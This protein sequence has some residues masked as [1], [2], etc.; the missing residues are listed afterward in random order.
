VAV[1]VFRIPFYGDINVPA[2]DAGAVAEELRTFGPDDAMARA[3]EISA[4]IQTAIDDPSRNVIELT[5]PH[6]HDLHL[7]LDRIRQEQPGGRM[8]IPLEALFD[9]C[10]PDD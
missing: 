3:R 1:V 8:S 10:A 2:E 9:A 6:R 7:A 4:A 5:D